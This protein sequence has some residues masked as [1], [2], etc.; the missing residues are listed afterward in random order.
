MQNGDEEVNDSAAEVAITEFLQE[1]FRPAENFEE[2]TITL[3]TTELQN[4][5]KDQYDLV[6]ISV[7]Y[8]ILKDLGYVEINMPGSNMKPVWLLKAK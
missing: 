4:K 7:L 6:K 8:K 2:A 3:D 1:N 5:L